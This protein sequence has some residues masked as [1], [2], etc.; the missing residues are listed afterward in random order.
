MKR[1][2]RM[3]TP[4]ERRLQDSARASARSEVAFYRLVGALSSV[5]LALRA[6]RRAHDAD[7]HPKV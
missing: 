6:I 4:L 5:M 7:Q 2:K 3:A 1:A